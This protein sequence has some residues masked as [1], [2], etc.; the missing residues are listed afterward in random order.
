MSKGIRE[1]IAL[2]VFAFLIVFAGVV[3]TSYF[4]TGRSWTK[5]ATFVDDTLGNMNGYTGIVFNGVL[6]EPLETNEEAAPS[7]FSS[8]SVSEMIRLTTLPLLERSP[9]GAYEGVFLSDVRDIYE[10]KGAKVIT[11]DLR[12]LGYYAV[13][14]VYRVGDKRIGVFSATSYLRP[15][16]V[17]TIVDDLKAKGASSVVCIAPREAFLST[18]KG[19]DILLLTEDRSLTN[20][21]IEDNDS[22]VVTSPSVGEIG[23]ILLS[24]NDVPLVREID[25]LQ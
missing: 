9:T 20:M 6:P 2:V 10:S 3:L 19:I 23:V 18:S 15:A 1:K 21:R 16:Q 8:G 13:P 14:T 22:T 7:P 12:N 5:A 24:T 17:E 4:S 25:S 11:L